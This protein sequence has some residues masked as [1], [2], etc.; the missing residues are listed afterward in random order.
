MVG[1]IDLNYVVDYN[2]INKCVEYLK[3]NF[4]Y[5]MSI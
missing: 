2:M 1:K 4:I 5:D 3:I